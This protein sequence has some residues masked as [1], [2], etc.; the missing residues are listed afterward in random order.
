MRV[1]SASND[2]RHRH[3]R[4]VAARAPLDD[5]RGRRE[6]GVPAEQRAAQVEHAA[7]HAQP[8]VA[9]LAGRRH[10]GPDEHREDALA[11]D[12][13][14][15][16][17]VLGGHGL[18]PRHVGAARTARAGRGSACRPQGRR[19]RPR[20]RRRST[21]RPGR[22]GARSRWGSRRRRTAAAGC[23]PRSSSLA[24]RVDGRVGAAADAT[25]VG[26]RGGQAARST[27]RGRSCRRPWCA[28]RL[29]VAARDP[30]E[31]V[32]AYTASTRSVPRRV[33][34][35]VSAGPSCEAERCVRRWTGADEPPGR[36]ARACAAH[37]GTDVIGH[38]RAHVRSQPTSCGRGWDG[39]AP[40]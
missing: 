29:D 7:R 30:V 33:N 40:S 18:E 9:H 25:W 13:R 19:H 6:L 12:E 21:P 31:S 26:R 20:R 4:L 36:Q 38:R 11:V 3:D 27:R 24:W 15:D 16:R 8:V 39:A 34:S 28:R 5:Q 32:R 35:T 10:R 17:A 22:A 37:G 23:P 2:D 14:G 1:A